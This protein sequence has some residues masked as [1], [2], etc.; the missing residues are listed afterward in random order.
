M[1]C[2]AFDF[3]R[4]AVLGGL[5]ENSDPDSVNLFSKLFWKK[6]PEKNAAERTELLASFTTPHRPFP[7]AHAAKGGG[8]WDAGRLLQVF[9]KLFCFL[10]PMSLPKRILERVRFP[11]R[12][13][14][15][16]AVARAA[17]GRHRHETVYPDSGS[18]RRA[19]RRP[20]CGGL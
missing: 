6:L 18:Y 20:H 13:P 9:S 1:T 16:P 5:K 11:A 4:C 15:Q 2:V 14:F 17:H 7:A 3:R 12:H 10:P 19:A 8:T